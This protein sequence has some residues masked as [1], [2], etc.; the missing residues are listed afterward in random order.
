MLA[1]KAIKEVAAN[2]QLYESV[3]VGKYNARFF[4]ILSVAELQATTK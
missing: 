3:T 2:V 4:F 1:L